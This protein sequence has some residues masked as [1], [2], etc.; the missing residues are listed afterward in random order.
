MTEA[1]GNPA[2]GT[3]DG[4]PPPGTAIARPALRVHALRE[5][6]LAQFT[7]P[8]GTRWAAVPGADDGAP[9]RQGPP[10]QE[11]PGQRPREGLSAS[12]G[13]HTGAPIG[14][15]RGRCRGCLGRLIADDCRYWRMRI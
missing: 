14:W 9:L 1:T 5:R 2:G 3:G 15:R 7:S 8:A 10:R 11:A 4:A 6:H 13:L 12:A